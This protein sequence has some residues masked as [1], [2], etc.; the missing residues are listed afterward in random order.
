VRQGLMPAP[1]KLKSKAFTTGSSNGA[2]WRR[3]DPAATAEAKE[4]AEEK[5][6]RDDALEDAHSE[7]QRTKAQR[8]DEFKDEHRRG[9]G[10]RANRG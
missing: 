5:T 3:I 7:E 2:S 6:A 8:F 9:S 4:A 1:Q 10:N